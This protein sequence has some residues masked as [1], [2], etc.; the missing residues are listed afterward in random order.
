MTEDDILLY[1]VY[2]L[3]GFLPAVIP[4]L[5]VILTGPRV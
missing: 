5:V 3:S 1:A 2:F 4:A